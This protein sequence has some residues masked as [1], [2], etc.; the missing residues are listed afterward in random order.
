MLSHFTRLLAILLFTS[1]IGCMASVQV[2]LLQPADITLPATVKT[3]AVV[4]RSAVGDAGEG[5]LSVLE[6]LATDE[7]ILGDREGAEEAIEKLVH[8]LAA[9]PRFSAVPVVASRDQV[10]SS[11]FDEELPFETVQ[12]LCADAQ[13][14]ALVAL[15]YF[16]SDTERDYE[17]RRVESTDSDGKKT[18][19]VVHDVS[20]T[21]EVTLSWRVYDATRPVLLDEQ[22]KIGITEVDN[23]SGS[24]RRN[25][26]SKLQGRDRTIKAIGSRAGEAYGQRIAPSYVFENRL[27]YKDKD[28]RLK[29]ASGE[30][31]EDRWEPAKALWQQVL[32]DPDPDLA[33]RAAYNLALSLELEGLIDDAIEMVERAVEL[34]DNG[35]ARRYRAILLQRSRDLGR[36]DS[37][38]EQSP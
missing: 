5:M 33:G 26:R 29:E 12:L 17:A 35:E 6:G 15:D 30:V 10:D 31:Q 18:V 23:A 27:Y 9:S 21:I 32:E 22:D 20:R 37:Q 34:L 2:R 8:T 7:T 28:D 38:M 16:D 1:T 14:E 4:D 3:L 13:A 19:R 25:A 36:L 24:S 11:L